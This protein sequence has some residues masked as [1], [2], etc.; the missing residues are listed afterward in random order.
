MTVLKSEEGYDGMSKSFP[1]HVDESITYPQTR[2]DT[3]R[4][5]SMQMCACARIP[6]EVPLTIWVCFLFSRLICVPSHP[7]TLFTPFSS[8]SKPT[9]ISSHTV[10]GSNITASPLT[11]DEGQQ[12]IAHSLRELSSCSSSVSLLLVPVI[13]TLISSL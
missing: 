2:H 13:C 3:T 12:A 4:Q 8:V 9:E 5:S 11:E 7:S 1:L 6:H 10:R